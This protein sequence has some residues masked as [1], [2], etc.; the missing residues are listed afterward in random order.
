MTPG[1]PVTITRPDGTSEVR[2]RFA[3]PNGT[4]EAYAGPH[5]GQTWATRAGE[6]T[7]YEARGRVP[8]LSRFRR[9][10]RL[11]PKNAE[12]PECAGQSYAI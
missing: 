12:G 7:G 10:R 3:C 4:S 11:S 1:W 6:A 8:R 2:P 9:S 5:L